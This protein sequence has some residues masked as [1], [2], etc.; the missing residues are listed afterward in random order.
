[1]SDNLQSQQQTAKIIRFPLERRVSR[2][3]EQP[4]AR[5]VAERPAAVVIESGSGWYHEAAMEDAGLSRHC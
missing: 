4:V 5:K 3:S 2:V 1:M